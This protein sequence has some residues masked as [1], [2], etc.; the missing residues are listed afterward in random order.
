MFVK[1]VPS[2]KLL[3]RCHSHM[4][5]ESSMYYSSAEGDF[6]KP[7]PNIHSTKAEYVLSFIYICRRYIKI[8]FLSLFIYF[9]LNL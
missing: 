7:K 4:D 9:E 3:Q 5:D 8:K 6:L 2:F 1:D